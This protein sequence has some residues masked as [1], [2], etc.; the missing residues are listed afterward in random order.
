[1][2]REVAEAHKEPAW[3]RTRFEL[4]RTFGYFVTESSE[5]F[6]EYVPWFIKQNR[7]D[8]IQKY[9]IPL[10][11]YPARC[12]NQIADWGEFRSALLASEPDALTELSRGQARRAARHDR[13]PHRHGR[14]GRPGSGR[15]VARGSPV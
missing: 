11:E 8:L 13:A 4:F 1:M 12:E 2:L 6:S 15:C 9:N 14:Q 5:H 10:D 7:D 3:E